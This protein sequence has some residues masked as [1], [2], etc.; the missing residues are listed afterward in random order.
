MTQAQKRI[1]MI[2]VLLTLILAV[3]DQN[4]VAT[5]SWSIV[6]ELDPVHGLER[7]PWLV[8]AYSLAATAA[9]PLYGKLCDVY[10]AKH[11]YLGAVGLF[12]AGSALCA[13]AQDMGQLIA[14]RAVQ[15]LG[16]GGL[17]SV[18]MIVAAHLTPP[19]QRASA[20]GAGGLIAG[21]GLVAGPLLG[22][23]FTDHATWRWIFYLNLPV[24]LFVLV[25]AAIAIRLG[26]GGLRHRIDYPGAALIAMAACLL[27]LIVEWGGKIY[28][29]DSAT[30]VALTGLDVVLF[31]AFAWRQLTAAEPI[32][33]LS[34]FRHPT[35]RIALPL[36]LLTGLGMAGGIFY[37][38]IYLQV[39]A[40]VKATDSG[41]YL[42]PMAIG[43]VV[44][45]TI[46]GVLIGRGRDTKPF[47]IAGM[48]CVTAAM[49][50]LSRLET[51]TS[52]WTLRF[53][54]FVMG[55]GF[56]MVL[57]IVVMLVQNSA[58]RSQLGVATT[59]IR[60]VQVLGS[61]LG[62]ATFGI[63]LN[64]TTESHLP[65]GTRAGSLARAVPPEARERVVGALLSGV[66]VVFLSA[67]G[68]MAVAVL[69]AVFLRTSPALPADPPAPQRVGV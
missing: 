1:A 4:I 63:L 59:S 62:T 40:G 53:D 65:P 10:G 14:F 47:L 36:Q 2:G 31:A 57:G 3:L 50:L 11:V 29:W 19:Q 18:T 32:L 13:L 30:I 25:S 7:L 8:T 51:A 42:I 6:R 35:L 68:V 56:G 41:L 20:G 58:P 61:A 23:V 21:L 52:A 60:F 48:A 55:V 26:D 28:A 27:L 39:V 12:L 54:L 49:V 22:G 37:T 69:L 5:A 66:H 46:S 9:L 67:A 33:P 15:G 44:S 64:R 43:M 16:G 45:G 34:M 17:M 24:G 38:V